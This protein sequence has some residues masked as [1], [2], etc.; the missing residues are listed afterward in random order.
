M[1]FCKP[2][3]EQG[4]QMRW[5]I[6]KLH[7]LQLDLICNLKHVERWCMVCSMSIFCFSAWAGKSKN[8]EHKCTAY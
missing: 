3:S 6:Y 8:I 4:I 2:A 5:L 1:A 7:H